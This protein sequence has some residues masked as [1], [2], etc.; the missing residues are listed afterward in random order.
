[1]FIDIFGTM[2]EAGV[3][4]QNTFLCYKDI[5]N[6]VAR[7]AC[8]APPRIVR[9]VDSPIPSSLSFLSLSESKEFEFT[10]AQVARGFRLPVFLGEPAKVALPSHAQS[11]TPLNSKEPSTREDS[12]RKEGKIRV[13][14]TSALVSNLRNAEGKIAPSSP[15]QPSVVDQGAAADDKIT[16][17]MA[18]KGRLGKGRR[19]RERLRNQCAVSDPP[20]LNVDLCELLSSSDPAPPQGNLLKA[21]ELRRPKVVE[22][23]EKASHEVA[24]ALILEQGE[25]DS[26]SGS[27]TRVSSTVP[28]DTPMDNHDP[29]FSPGPV[30]EGDSALLPMP[31]RSVF[32]GKLK[33]GAGLALAAAGAAG[34][35]AVSRP[36]LL[37]G[38]YVAAGIQRIMPEQ[39]LSGDYRRQHSSMVIDEQW[40]EQSTGEGQ[41][42]ALRAAMPS[43]PSRNR[44]HSRRKPAASDPAEPALVI[45]SVPPSPKRNPPSVEHRGPSDRDEPRVDIQMQWLEH[46][47][48]DGCGA[49]VAQRRGRQPAS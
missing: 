44:L 31:S 24:L 5:D 41:S 40:M 25:P 33:L 15:L 14:A 1:M 9:Y 6:S 48:E 10:W 8:S 22:A 19:R 36:D 38:P 16:E 30:R 13:A 46:S 23:A 29:V 34:F 3:T 43:R 32:R 45:E 42:Y 21:E 27:S 26:E 12:C 18:M 37:V 20:A 47:C 17:S 11:K 39:L 35:L 28:S 2:E 49:Y 7:R 4:I